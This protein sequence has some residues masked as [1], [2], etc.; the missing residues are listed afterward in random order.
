MRVVVNAAMSADGKLAAR[1]RAQLAISGPDDFD[2]VDAMRANSDAVMVGIETVLSDDPGLTVDAQER[3]T[4]REARGASRQPARVIADS[5]A[6]TPVGARVCDDA[7]Q[8]F[9]L[10]SEAAP[11]QRIDAFRAGGIEVIVAGDSRVDLAAGLSALEANGVSDLMVEGGGELIFGLVA[12]GL[13]DELSVYIGAM[14]IG[15]REA[16]TLVDGKGFV[17]DFSEL[18]LQSV[19]RLDDGVVLEW[20]VDTG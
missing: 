17:D 6:R 4:E 1:D 9:V 7:A 19:S 20:N 5:R 16:P 2:R 11:V 3:I 13:V 15:G 18:S 10:V 14:L 12:A 8:T